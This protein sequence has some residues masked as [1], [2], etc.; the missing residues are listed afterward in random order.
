MDADRLK[1]DLYVWTAPRDLDVDAAGDL[2]RAWEAAG[3]DPAQSP[4]EASTDIVWFRRELLNDL[5]GLEVTSDAV[6]KPSRLPIVLAANDE[7]PA[8]VIAIRLPRDDVEAL[9]VAL[10]EI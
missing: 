4:F 9:R 2:V 5:P 7:P 3:G 10:E 1:F 6:P 8:R